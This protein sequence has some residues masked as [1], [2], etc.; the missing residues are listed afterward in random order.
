MIWM[1]GHYWQG[2]VEARISITDRGLLLGDGLF[3]TLLVKPE[4]VVFFAEH[5]E[6]LRKSA[7][8]LSIPIEYTDDE[9]A[10]AIMKLCDASTSAVRISLSRGAASRGLAPPAQDQVQPVLFITT[11]PYHYQPSPPAHQAIVSTIRRN[12]GSI[13]TQLKTLSYLD[14][15]CAIQEARAAGADEAIM[16][17]NRGHLACVTIGNIFLFHHGRLATPP[18]GDGVLPGITRGKIMQLADALK[19]S[20]TERHL[21][22]NE[23]QDAFVFMTNSLVGLREII[24]QGQPPLSCAENYRSVFREIRAAYHE[25]LATDLT[26]AK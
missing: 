19:I 11:A 16:C 25:Q 8:R 15:I 3:E 24:V 13:A 14:N 21:K 12:E 2:E 5:M 23:L 17:N 20:V 18:L 22:Q 26:D 1:N 4:G 10:T 9:I 7:G 6:R